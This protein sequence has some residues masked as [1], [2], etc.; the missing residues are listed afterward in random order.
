MVWFGSPSLQQAATGTRK[1]SSWEI[2]SLT[3]CSKSQ[4]VT[5]N[6]GSRSCKEGGWWWILA[7]VADGGR[8]YRRNCPKVKLA[9]SCQVFLPSVSNVPLAPAVNNNTPSITRD[10]IKMD[11]YAQP[12]GSITRTASNE[13]L[14]RSKGRSWHLSPSPCAKIFFYCFT[15]G[16]SIH[17][18]CFIAALMIVIIEDAE[19]L[20]N[21]VSSEMAR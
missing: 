14:A 17:V 8:K 16:R 11:S 4:K 6:A 1:P 10:P 13:I 18:L 20:W 7:S 9:T 19:Y 2:V 15:A 5:I 21:A 12:S 3:S